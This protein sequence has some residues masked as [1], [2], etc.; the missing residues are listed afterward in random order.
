MDDMQLGFINQQEL[1]R[2]NAQKKQT[3][4]AFSFA[5]AF[6]ALM[7]SF[8]MAESLINEDVFRNICYALA[9]ALAALASGI[10]DISFDDARKNALA[11]MGTEIFPIF[12]NMF[13]YLLNILIP[14]AILAKAAGI[15]PKQAFQI[16]TDYPKKFWLYIPFTM[17]ADYIVNLVVKLIFGDSLNRFLETESQLPQTPAGIVLYFIM[18]A[19][20]P[21]IFEEW[22]F[23]GVLLR[24]LLPYGKTFALVVSSVTFG[25]MHV[26]PPQAAFAVCFGF[27][28]GFIY[29][30]T[31]SIWYGALIHLLT[32]A[33]ATFMS[34]T[35]QFKDLTDPLLVFQSMIV[36]GAI[37]CFIVG[38]I[39][40]IRSGFFKTGVMHSIN[41]PDKPKLNVKQYFSLS[42]ANVFTVLFVIFYITTLIIR[43]YPELL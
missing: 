17:G 9:D 16:N 23:R 32:N 10:T 5:I 40:F 42:L 6:S 33:Y 38:L 8:L 13:I 21:A 22:A 25:L 31:G 41:P 24:S 2:N 15:R 37:V 43:Y 34:Y 39:I 20:L 35:L 3:G 30:K 11:F 19:F 4:K 27:F 26:N 7:L 18:I 12:F 1:A 29:I 36:I 14:F 28:A